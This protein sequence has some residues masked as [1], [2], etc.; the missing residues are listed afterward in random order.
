MELNKTCPPISSDDL[1][2]FL[3]IYPSPMLSLVMDTLESTVEYSMSSMSHL[4]EEGVAGHVVTLCTLLGSS[5]CSISVL[6][7]SSGK[8]A[9]PPSGTGDIASLQ[10]RRL[11]SQAATAGLVRPNDAGDARSSEF[12]WLEAGRRRTGVPRHRGLQ[13][14]ARDRD[15]FSSPLTEARNDLDGDWKRRADGLG[16]SSPR[17]RLHRWRLSRRTD[18]W[19][20]SSSM[21]PPRV[22]LRRCWLHPNGGSRRRRW[23]EFCSGVLTSGPVPT[24]K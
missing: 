22:Q 13:G 5:P 20:S 3:C 9:F 21:R 15:P 19:T 6:V 23:K 18:C 1:C 24:E 7:W 11:P 8:T 12:P 10:R 4:V 14:P 16:L 2:L 17:W